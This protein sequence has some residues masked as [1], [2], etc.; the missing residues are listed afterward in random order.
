MFSEQVK[1]N[2]EIQEINQKLNE[3]LSFYLKT[4]KVNQD[5]LEELLENGLVNNKLVEEV[6]EWLNLKQGDILQVDFYDPDLELDLS[7]G[8]D[9]EIKGG[10]LNTHQKI[11]LLVPV[12]EKKIVRRHLHI[13]SHSLNLDLRGKEANKLTFK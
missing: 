1:K 10:N 8:G 2:L 3:K 7:D 6:E 5:Q 9:N 4:S 12:V 13:K 11:G